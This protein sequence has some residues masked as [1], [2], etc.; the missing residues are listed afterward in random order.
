MAN[1]EHLAVLKQGVKMW[2]RWRMGNPTIRPDLSEAYLRRVYLRRANFILAD[3]R[4]A[5]LSMAD[6]IWAKLN[7]AD[8]CGANLS[9]A[10]LNQ[11]DLTLA[12]LRSTNLSEATLRGACLAG[13]HLNQADLHKADISESDLRGANLE[14]ADLTEAYLLGADFQGTNLRGA[15]LTK[16]E[17][18]WGEFGNVDLS[19]VKGLSTVDHHGPSTIG[20][21]TLYRSKGNIPGIFLRRAGV[22]E[23][24]ISYAHSRVKK[25]SRYYNCFISYSSKDQ[26]FVERLYE[27]LQNHGVRCWFAPQDIQG[28]KKIQEQIRQAI[29][30]YDKLLLVLSEYS[31]N[32]QWVEDEIRWARKREVKEN[33]RVLFPIRLVEFSVIEKWACFDADTKKDLAIEIREY[34]IPDFSN[35]EDTGAYNREF[36]RL[37]GA[38]KAEGPKE[39]PKQ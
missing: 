24:F 13:A 38:L 34:Y 19:E 21:D 16:A 20:I 23:D 31:M 3:L 7:Q 27:D 11:A 2:N 9:G 22:P 37:L 28:G 29:G 6:L 1:E 35:W 15:T 25:H 10:H 5:D 26:G 30:Q 17:V 8:L 4:G 32:S 12:K 33:R 18:G 39:E 14:D 36:D